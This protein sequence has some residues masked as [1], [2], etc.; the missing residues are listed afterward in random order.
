MVTAQRLLVVGGSG[1]IGAGIVAAFPGQCEVWS[2]RTGVDAA[3]PQSVGAAVEGLQ[4]ADRVPDAW[5][6]CVGDFDEVPLLGCPEEHYRHM[7]RSNLDTAFCVMQHLVPAM[8]ARGRGRIVFFG[9]SG[10]ESRSAKTRAPVY[11][12]AKAALLS[13][14]RSLAMEVAADGLCV[15]M[16]SPGII[17]HPDSH[18]ASQDRMQDKVPAG[19]CGE[20]G[21]V[22][23]TLRLLLGE[24]GAYLNGAHIEV[25]GGLGLI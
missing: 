3:D 1:G 7:L 15:N 11:F 16:V 6:H 24:E 22:L 4:A 13:L 25:D 20:V 9:A 17:R 18:S 14:A 21:D 19:R 2:R 5:L 23:P 10:L 8:R 12:A